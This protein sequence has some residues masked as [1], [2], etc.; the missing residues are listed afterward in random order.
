MYFRF[1]AGAEWYLFFLIPEASNARMKVGLRRNVQLLWWEL[2][3]QLVAGMNYC[4]LCQISP[5]VPNP[6]K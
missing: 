4:I 2:S 3:T 1:S 5:V 6:E